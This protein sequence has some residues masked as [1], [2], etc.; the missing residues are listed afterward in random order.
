RLSARQT[1]DRSRLQAYAALESLVAAFALALP[2]MLAA[3]QPL[4][5]WAY[6]DGLAPARFGI[7]RAFLCVGILGVPAAAMGATFPI[8]A[9]WFS[10]GAGSARDADWIVPHDRAARARRAFA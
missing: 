2:V 7:V 10:S 1:A 4:L 3:A 8:A 9:A 6:D 5:G